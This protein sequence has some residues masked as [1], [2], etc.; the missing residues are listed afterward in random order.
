MRLSIFNILLMIGLGFISWFYLTSFSKIVSNS[1][2]YK[3]TIILPAIA[4]ILTYLALK[5]IKKDDKLV[6]S[7]D[8]I[9]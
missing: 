7:V 1:I 2:H 4:I 5:A 6:K 3:L 8:R 9:R